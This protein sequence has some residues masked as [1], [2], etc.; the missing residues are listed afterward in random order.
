MEMY[1][2]DNPMY[3]FGCGTHVDRVCVLCKSVSQKV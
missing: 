2:Q 3:K 1:I